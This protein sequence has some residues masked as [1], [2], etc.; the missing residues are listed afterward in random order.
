MAFIFLT[1][2]D[3]CVQQVKSNKTKK[4]KLRFLWVYPI[5]YQCQLLWAPAAVFSCKHIVE[6]LALL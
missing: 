6:Y 2:P 5:L 3:I 1:A 4:K